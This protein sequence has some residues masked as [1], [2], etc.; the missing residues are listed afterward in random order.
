MLLNQMSWGAGG[1]ATPSARPMSDQGMIA[2]ALFTML[3]TLTAATHLFDTIN[4]GV[5]QITLGS[6]L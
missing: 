6:P 4:L 5:S 1:G 2:V 3:Y